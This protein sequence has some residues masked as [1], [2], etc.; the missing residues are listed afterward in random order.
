M[1]DYINGNKFL[2]IADFA[3]DFDH[4]DLSTEL[5]RKNAI[6]FCKT[7]FIG[8]LFDYIK[9]SRRK[10]IL[11]THMSDFE[12]DEYKFS[13]A[14]SSI[15]KW[16]AQ[17]AI[18]KNEKLVPI[19]LGL[20][21]HKGGSKG[22]FTNHEW[23]L[24]ENE[25]LRGFP[26]DVALYCNWNP[27]TN[28]EVRLPIINELEKNGQDLFIETGMTFEDYCYSMAHH[29]WVVCPPGN[30]AD[31]HRLWEAL[32]LGCYPIILK[33]PIYD[34]YHLPILQV[35]K[36]SD[37]SIDLLNKHFQKWN[38]VDYHHELRMSYWGNIIKEEFQEI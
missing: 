18:F 4:Q 6:I 5:F 23:F 21:N 8:L 28:Q 7:D 12:I 30:G 2:E 32:Y 11:I 33:N 14:P 15:I 38:G 36:W 27:D 34:N 26:K 31:T 37:V 24:K 29:K 16:Y 20:E 25:R 3:L 1:L 9:L 22:K 17:N 35:E 19:P 10:Y 13:L